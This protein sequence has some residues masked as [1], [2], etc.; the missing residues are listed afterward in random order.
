M[1]GIFSFPI[2]SS[3]FE[4]LLINSGVTSLEFHPVKLVCQKTKDVDDSYSFL[5]IL[6]NLL[7]FDWER[8]EFE[9]GFVRQD[10]VREVKKLKIL[11]EGIVKRDMV[12]MA[13]I[14]SAILMSARLRTIIESAGITG[15]QFQRLEEFQMP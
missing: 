9:T 15:V 6:D 8:S 12:R 1:A 2:I 14:P 11:E 13:E 7:C 5:N 4:E 3:R 10:V